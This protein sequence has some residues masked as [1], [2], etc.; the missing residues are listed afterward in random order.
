MFDIK[1]QINYKNKTTKYIKVEDELAS[2][3]N[4]LDIT[5][6]ILNRKYPEYE[7]NEIDSIII[8][9]LCDKMV[10]KLAGFKNIKIMTRTVG[11][12]LSS[13]SRVEICSN[14]D[15]FYINS[16]DI[17]EMFIDRSNFTIESSNM[18]RLITVDERGDNY[19]N[20]ECLGLSGTLREC[21][22]NRFD[23]H[24]TYKN[25]TIEDTRI[26]TINLKS[27]ITEC[28]SIINNSKVNEL[29]I[30]SEIECVS[31]IIDI[32]SIIVYNSVLVNCY[33][34]KPNTIVN[35]SITAWEIISKSAKNEGNYGIYS[36]ADYERLKLIRKERLSGISKITS[37]LFD[38]FCG[39]GY[40]PIRTIVLTGVLWLIF[41]SSY[42]VLT[43]LNLGGL[44]FE[45]DLISKL[46]IF[47]NCM[48]FSTITLTTTGFGE[49]TPSGISRFLASLESI[50]G[51]ISMALLV[52][53][54]TK[55]HGNY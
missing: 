1:I 14:V 29:Y 15:N 39:Y 49:I 28:I 10:L 50:I 4:W 22:I 27:R 45:E 11:T 38:L 46:K 51:V 36:L 8:D 24:T 2:K 42:Y 23:I 7:D 52:F 32:K 54:L 34:V 19:F 3:L 31:T 21:I 5:P 47:T 41:S 16:A 55:K 44:N 26:E 37:R 48:Y 53:G 25:I 35:K 20:Q 12:K 30:L 17:N 43:I 18:N 13:F 6:N 9:V 33:N 40:K